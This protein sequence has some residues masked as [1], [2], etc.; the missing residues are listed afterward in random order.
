MSMAGSETLI[1]CSHASYNFSV[2]N[3][4]CLKWAFEKLGQS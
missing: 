1:S 2:E 3:Y 4:L